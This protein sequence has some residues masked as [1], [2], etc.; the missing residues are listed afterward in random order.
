VILALV[1]QIEVGKD[2]IRI[3]YRLPP[4]PFRGMP[5]ENKKDW[6]VANASEPQRALTAI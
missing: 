1:K 4:V 2:E 3:V 5:L 6:P